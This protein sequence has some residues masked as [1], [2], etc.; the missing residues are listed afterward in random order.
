MMNPSQKLEGKKAEENTNI[1]QANAYPSEDG[2]IYGI[3]LLNLVK[4]AHDSVNDSK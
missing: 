3:D 1:D 4:P 2:H